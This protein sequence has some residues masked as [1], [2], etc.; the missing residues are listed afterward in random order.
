QL[1]AAVRVWAEADRVRLLAVRESRDWGGFPFPNRWAEE[2]ASRFA[3]LHGASHG[4]AVANGTVAIEVALRA[5]GIGAGDE[6]IVP[7]YTFEASAAPVLRLGGVPRFVGVGR[8]AY[9]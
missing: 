9:C 3:A 1:C 7:A 5:A 6:V 4:L 8:G 2:A